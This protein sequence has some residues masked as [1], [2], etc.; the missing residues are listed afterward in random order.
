MVIAAS[1][2]RSQ[3]H[4]YTFGRARQRT[5]IFQGHARFEVALNRILISKQYLFGSTSNHICLRTYVD[6]LNPFPQ[7][8]VPGNTSRSLFH[9]SMPTP[10]IG[11]AQLPSHV[12]EKAEQE[13]TVLRNKLNTEHS[14]ASLGYFKGSIMSSRCLRPAVAI[15]FWM[16]PLGLAMLVKC[17]ILPVFNENYIMFRKAF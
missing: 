11:S 13:E 7:F 17:G 10:C 15:S 5:R 16:R 9:E 1:S 12:M 3:S 6:G 2:F 8:A 14:I 4:R